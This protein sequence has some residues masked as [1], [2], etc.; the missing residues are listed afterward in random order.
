MTAIAALL[1][2]ALSLQQTKAQNQ[3]AESGQITDRFNAAVTNLGSSTETIRIGGIYALQRIMQDS[4]RDQPAAIQ[5]LAAFV[6]EHAPLTSTAPDGAPTPAATKASPP[7]RPGI[8]V[9]TALSV[10]GARDPDHD[11]RTSV[12]LHQS[13]LQGANL[14]GANLDGAD[15]DGADLTLAN[16][17]DVHLDNA[18]LS[19]ANL[20]FATVNN[21]HLDGASVFSASLKGT[22]LSGASLKGA[23]LEYAQLNCFDVAFGACA[24]LLDAHLENADF[25]GANL[26]GADLAGA[27]LHRADFYNADLSGATVY[28]ADFTGADLDNAD[29]DNA[30]ILDAN[31]SGAN[32]K[33]AR[34]TR[35]VLTGQ[36]WC[37]A[38]GRPTVPAGYTCRRPPTP[39]PRPTSAQELQPAGK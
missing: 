30:E 18:D 19:D 10:L 7:D 22:H 35:A 5:V 33:G 29:L 27:H 11:Q 13:E 32:L 28:G 24:D 2:T 23:R 21:A 20:N 12:D 31:F 15:L 4:P 25:L 39:I 14:D 37:D 6:R 9:Q 1:F 16:L 38:D 34:F 26:S 17:T 36:R 3:L 8:D